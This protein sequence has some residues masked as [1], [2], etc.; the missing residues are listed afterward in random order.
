[1]SGNPPPST[2]ENYSLA[3]EEY[4]R[5][6]RAFSSL[7]PRP[8][9]YGR[10]VFIRHPQP[11]IPFT[12]SFPVNLPRR[13]GEAIDPHVLGAADTTAL[14]FPT[15]AEYRE[16]L[17]AFTDDYQEARFYCKIIKPYAGALAEVIEVS[18]GSSRLQRLPTHV[19]AAHCAQPRGNNP[20]F[21]GQLLDPP[22]D[23]QIYYVVHALVLAAYCSKIPMPPPQ[24]PLPA[25]QSMRFA[26]HFSVWNISV[27]SP[28]TFGIFLDVVYT[29]DFTRL[30][31]TLLPHWQPTNPERFM[32]LYNY[33]G[34]KETTI[35]HATY[36][37]GINSYGTRVATLCTKSMICSSL[38]KVLAF[39]ANATGLGYDDQLLF[40]M[41]GTMWQAL[42]L[43][44]AHDG[45]RRVSRQS[46]RSS[47]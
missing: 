46:K 19:L 24:L 32:V 21:F 40:S 42:T 41:I 23:V 3:I 28:E 37:S 20:T 34:Y 4:K 11:N 6:A 14:D 22:P 31:E 45:N 2:G 13:Q 35:L 7:H 12:F 44:L 27:P 38:S 43:A 39:W 17:A 33:P 36:A 30:M 16:N 29:R 47:S 9:F 8:V 10:P 5:A 26:A 15:I 25:D 1:M 18:I